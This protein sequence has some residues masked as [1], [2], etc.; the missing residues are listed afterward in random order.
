MAQDKEQL[1]K[2]YI[3]ALSALRAI[4][5]VE[6]RGKDQKLVG[7]HFKFRNSYSYPGPAD[8]WWAYFRA[9]R[10]D[11]CGLTGL[12]FQTDKDGEVTVRANTRQTSSLTGYAPCTKGEFNKAWGKVQARI[13]KLK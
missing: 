2:T 8:Y 7:K 10:L 5:E 11:D 12:A 4:E 3:E 6:Q 1:R 13:A 9:D